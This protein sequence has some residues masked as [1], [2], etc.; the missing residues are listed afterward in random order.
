MPERTARPLYGANFALD[1]ASAARS[2][3][4]PNFMSLSSEVSSFDV[5]VQNSP[6]FTVR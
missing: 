4:F 2:D 5:L 3:K 6:V 1:V